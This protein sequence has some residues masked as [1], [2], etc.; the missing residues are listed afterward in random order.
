MFLDVLR[1][2]DHRVDDVSSVRC[3]VLK[4]SKVGGIY[5]GDCQVFVV[6]SDWQDQVSSGDLLR[7]PLQ[8]ITIDGLVFEVDHRQAGVQSSDS[9]HISRQNKSVTHQ[10]LTQREA[11]LLSLCGGAVDLFPGDH[12]GL[13]KYLCQRGHDLE[14]AF[15][16]L[17]DFIV[18]RFRQGEY[19]RAV[20]FDYAFCVSVGLH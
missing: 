5:H 17:R 15:R 2:R 19:H 4:D 13:D 6:L 8:G 7:E 14:F 11:F 16:C 18:H 3:Q 10:H 20:A 9:C 1:R 12:A